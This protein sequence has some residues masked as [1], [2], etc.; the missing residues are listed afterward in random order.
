MPIASHPRQE[1]LLEQLTRLFLAEGFARFTLA[2]L[3][4]H[5]RCSK[6]TLYALGHSKEALT[7]AVVRRFFRTAT[8]AVEAATA[9]HAEPADRL[10]AYLRAVADELRPAGETFMR[11]VVAHPATR[12]IYERNT[13][14]AAERVREIIAAG[15][16]AG[17]FRAADARF[18]AD[19]A[20]AYM[21]RI[22]SGEASDRTGLSH[23][24][25]YDELSRLLLLGVAR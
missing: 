8:T 5:L 15:A 12:E 6:S 2:E 20:A 17:V 10:T 22:Q 11:D 1:E 7:V 4:A 3:A 13:T 24:D 14:A 9:Q 18:V 16:D 25:A 19:L 21:T 23:A